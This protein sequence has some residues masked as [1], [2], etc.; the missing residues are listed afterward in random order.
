MLEFKKVSK[1]FGNISAVSDVS[2]Y[3]EPGELVFITGAS[4]AG[5]TTLLR[6][7]IRQFTPSEGEI[8]F[9]EMAVHELKNRQI[10]KLRREI[11]SVFQDYQLLSDRT[12]FENALVALAVAGTPK[13][14][15][16]A[17]VEQ[18]MKLVGLLERMDLFP[19]QLSGGEQQRAALARALVMNPKLVF[20]DEPTGNLDW[21]TSS[22]I[23]ELMQKINK[24]GKTVIITTHSKELV[25]AG[26]GREIELKDG[27]VIKDSDPKTSGDKQSSADEA[28]DNKK[29]SKK[30]R[31]ED[32]QTHKAS[33]D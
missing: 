17:R 21:E 14:E 2:F 30:D 29:D 4:G 8:M 7:L 18:V 11:G 33:A 24:E 5:K 28:G 12:V 31:T 6:L 15:R 1:N 20:A 22:S 10:P 23:L 25:K 3:I 32:R 26:G 27:K 19:S 13:D 16:R 9:D